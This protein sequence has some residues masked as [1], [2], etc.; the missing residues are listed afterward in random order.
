MHDSRVT[1]GQ[2]FGSRDRASHRPAM[3]VDLAGRLERQAGAEGTL[4]VQMPAEICYPGWLFTRLTVLAGRQCWPAGRINRVL[5]ASRLCEIPD[6]GRQDI[7]ALHPCPH[8]GTTCTCMYVYSR[9]QSPHAAPPLVQY[10]PFSE[11]CQVLLNVLRTR[12]D[13][14]EGHCS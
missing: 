8:S 13:G 6:S 9:L 4:P 1:N 14:D 10:I 5:S 7:R 2:T 11:H 12:R 3:V